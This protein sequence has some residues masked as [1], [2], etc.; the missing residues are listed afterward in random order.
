M[1]VVAKELVYYGDKRRREGEGFVLTDPKH[2]SKRSMRRATEEDGVVEDA[3][4]INK[5]ITV[6]ELKAA[7]K[8]AGVA[9]K[10][11]A[12]KAE[13]MDLYG[14]ITAPPAGATE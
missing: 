8:K 3:E 13:L 10:P 9:F 7:L 12:N 6:K 11:N 5:E 4:P 2:F 14:K 1:K